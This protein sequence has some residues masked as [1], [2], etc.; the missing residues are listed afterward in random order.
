ML[1]VTSYIHN[2]HT[3]KHTQNRPSQ[4]PTSC[5]RFKT[6]SYIHYTHTH[7]THTKQAVTKADVLRAI[8]NYLV[9]VFEPSRANMCITTNAGQAEQIVSA[10]ESS[11]WTVTKTESID[12][13]V[14]DGE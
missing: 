1:R 5:A 8:Q 4:K 12:E 3:H 7:T 13:V 10:F 2:A 9:H 14:K 6:T 11:G